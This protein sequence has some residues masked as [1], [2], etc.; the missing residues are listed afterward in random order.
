MRDDKR[1]KMLPDHFESLSGPEKQEE[2]SGNAIFWSG[3]RFIVLCLAL[4]LFT[5]AVVFFLSVHKKEVVS[6][7]QVTGE[8]LVNALIELQEKYLVPRILLKISND[9]GDAGTI[10]YQS[11]ASG[12]KVVIGREI[13]LTVSKGNLVDKVPNYIGKALYQIQNDAYLLQ[14]VS[15]SLQ[16]GSV[17]YVGRSDVEPGRILAQK[18]QPGEPLAMPLI[19]EFWVSSKQ[20]EAAPPA[21][22]ERPESAESE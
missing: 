10:L 11:P 9:S 3:F 20:G 14:Y 21:Q 5:V 8:P 16:I 1:K 4:L 12:A 18:P 19:V 17:Y 13:L 7:P 2:L 6:V 15:G 22:E